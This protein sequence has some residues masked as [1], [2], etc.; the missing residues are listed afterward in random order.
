MHR[1]FWFWCRCD[2]NQCKAQIGLPHQSHNLIMLRPLGVHLA[3][4]NNIVSDSETTAL[5]DIKCSNSRKAANVKTIILLE[6]IY[7]IS[8][9][10]SVEQ[11]DG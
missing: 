1:G 6:S 8:S 7:S 3:N 11:K 2:K 10:N 9:K 4:S 5:M